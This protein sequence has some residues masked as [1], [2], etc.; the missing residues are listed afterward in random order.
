MFKFATFCT[1]TIG[2]L[3]VVFLFFLQVFIPIYRGFERRW[4]LAVTST[5]LAWSFDY[6]PLRTNFKFIPFETEQHLQQYYCY[7]CLDVETSCRDGGCRGMRR[8]SGCTLRTL[9]FV[10]SSEVASDEML[11]ITLLLMTL[12]LM[13]C[14][15]ERFL[16]TRFFRRISSDAFL[17][18]AILS[19]ALSFYKIPLLLDLFNQNLY[20]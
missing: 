7:S 15:Q 14:L 16:Q 8:V 10:N 6:S 20:G 1:E 2:L 4:E 18:D 5:C 13:T 19:D 3:L 9:Y 11:L 17:S 12:L